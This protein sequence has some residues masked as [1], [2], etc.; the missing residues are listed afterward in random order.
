MAKKQAPAKE[1]AEP[2]PE[3]AD[4]QNIVYKPPGPVAMA[5]HKSDAF[6][7]GIRGPI[8]SG[9]S[10][11]C[12]VEIWRRAC[13]IPRFRRDGWRRSRWAVVRG[14]YPE[15]LMTT[16]PLWL[17]WFPEEIFGRF[18]YSIPYHHVLIDEREKVRAEVWFVS[19]DKPKD[20]KKVLSMNL[21]GAYLNEA[22][23]LEKENIDAVTSR[24]GRYPNSRLLENMALPWGGV[25]ADTNSPHEAHW[26]PIM[27]G[28]VTPPD[29]LSEDDRRMLVKPK[30]WEF[31]EQPPAML[32]QPDGSLVTN[33][34]AENLI[35]L[36]KHYYDNLIQGKRMSWIKVMVLNQIGSHSDTASVQT[37]FN[38]AFHVAN[39]TIRFNPDLPLY[40]GIDGGLTPAAVLFQHYRHLGRIVVLREVVTFGRGMA[41]LQFAR[42]L[43]RVLHEHFDDALIEIAW[44]DPSTDE[45]DKAQG[46]IP[47]AMF[48]SEG[49]PARPAPTNIIETRVAVVDLCLE[50]VVEGQPMLLID[51]ACSTLI[52]GLDG[53][54]KRARLPYTGEV[55]YSEAAVKNRWS[56]VCEALQ[57]GLVGLLGVQFATGNV[58]RQ[59]SEKSLSTR[60]SRRQERSIRD[61]ARQ[62]IRGGRRRSLPRFTT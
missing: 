52:Q 8:G 16:V 39:G 18:R 47:L 21:T 45:R 49:I 6:F 33:P 50:R 46:N 2:T 5:F 58:A 54:F 15:L 24:V 10:S 26:W 38:S 14:T 11:T 29:T 20:A 56:H 4:D 37:G 3:A 48:R 34:E 1:P 55:M 41:A 19:M 62:R 36:N 30:N 27:E 7:R 13:S 42:H 40:A 28:V 12:M 61:R 51:P 35:N 31:F 32:V 9:K 53:E 43:K 44:C 23:E 60:Q 57:Y 22:R 59:R 25:I 17:E